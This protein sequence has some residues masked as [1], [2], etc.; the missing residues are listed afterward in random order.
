MLLSLNGGDVIANGGEITLDSTLGKR[1]FS[2]WRKLMIWTGLIAG[3]IFLL[4]SAGFAFHTFEFL[5]HSV[6]TKGT[7][8]KLIGRTDSH[9]ETSYTPVFQFTA[10]D[11]QTYITA[12]DFA[13]SPPLYAVGQTIPVLYEP[14][15]PRTAT[16]DSFWTLWLFSLVFFVFGVG[17]TGGSLLLR[18][19]VQRRQRV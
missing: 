16:L 9:G 17:V 6:R 5:L 15:K 12:T 13:S 4:A 3:P 18:F 19:L 8:V 11:G 10:K 2:D 7:V 1:T 14:G